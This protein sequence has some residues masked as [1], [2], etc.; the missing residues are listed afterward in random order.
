MNFRADF[1]KNKVGMEYEELT[2]AACYMDPQSM[3]S[4]IMHLQLHIHVHTKVHTHL[5]RTSGLSSPRTRSAWSM[6]SSQQQRAVWTQKAETLSSNVCDVTY[7]FKPNFT[8]TLHE[9]QG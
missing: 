5:A 4:L 8:P 2:A 3:H 7:M 9:L 1:T 6:R